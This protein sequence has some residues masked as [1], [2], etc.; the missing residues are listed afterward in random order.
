VLISSALK[1]FSRF[2]AG[3]D[4]I[5]VVCVMSDLSSSGFVDCCEVL[6]SSRLGCWPSLLFGL[7]TDFWPECESIRVRGKGKFGQGH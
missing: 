2:L 4:S 5:M 7:V 6:R 3:S 1:S